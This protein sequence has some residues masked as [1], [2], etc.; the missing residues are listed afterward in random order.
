M[1]LGILRQASL[2]QLEFGGLLPN[3]PAAVLEQQEAFNVFNRELATG[4]FEVHWNQNLG[5]EEI[6]QLRRFV[7]V[8]GI[9][10]ADWNHKDIQRTDLFSIFGGKQVA[11]VA[12]V[13]QPEPVK[14]VDKEDIG[15]ALGPL[16]FIVEAGMSD[17]ANSL[18]EVFSG[19]VYQCEVAR[20][21]LVVRVI[22]MLMGVRDNIRRNSGGIVAGLGI[23]GIC[24][25][26]ETRVRR[27]QKTRVAN[28]L[29]CHLLPP[30]LSTPS[31][32]P[33]QGEGWV[34]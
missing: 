4:G 34:N 8:Y 21:S 20:D 17:D 25:D 13:T 30:F 1:N 11:E 29:K 3:D 31:P 7:T 6:R 19:S 18:G 10:A 24:D 14:F 32:L 27:H 2:F 5:S 16:G 9:E 28:P 33:S 12:R 23:V 26:A 22:G 15:T